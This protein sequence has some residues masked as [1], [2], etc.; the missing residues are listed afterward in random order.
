MLRHGVCVVCAL[1]VVACGGDDDGPNPGGAGGSAGSP[2]GNEER[3]QTLP[4]V[5]QEHA[6]VALGGEIYV[7]GGFAPGPTATVDAYDPATD[8]W[9]SVAEL[10]AALQHANAAAVN[11]KLYVAGYYP[12]VNF[13]AA[14]PYVLEFDP[15]AN[16]WS[17]PTDRTPMT[18]GTQRATACVAELGGKIYLFG[19][20]RGGTVAAA[21][22]YDPA[23]D[24]WEELP[25][26]PEP[27][28]HCAAGAIDGSIII[29][30]GRSNGIGGF[31]PKTYAY[32]PASRQYTEKAPIPTPR[33]GTAG[34]VLHGKL[35]VF[36][37]EGNSADPS[38]VFPKVEAYDPA[39]DSWEAYPDMLVPRHGFGAAVVG[40]RIY[41]PGGA[42]Q[43]AFGAV[44]DHSAFY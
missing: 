3:L 4:T 32:D 13:S 6:V 27:R 22:A 40:D 14:E 16:T 36:G 29:A 15:A 39:T 1:L 21:S 25:A 12:G 19:G 44:N 38:G 2:S 5:R 31:Q 24:S 23:A 33:G 37:G 20:G 41:L 35:F 7:I 10:P 18:A 8:Q 43:Q 11:G 17:D 26:L 30:S 34:A 9:R 42:T 28:E